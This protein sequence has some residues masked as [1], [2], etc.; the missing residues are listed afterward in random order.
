MGTTTFKTGQSGNPKGRPRLR[1]LSVSEYIGRRIG[2]QKTRAALVGE[3]VRIATKGDSD[4]A[5]LKAI[6]ALFEQAE[7]RPAQRTAAKAEDGKIEVI[8]GDDKTPATS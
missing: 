1:D 2:A 5:R 6:L 7:G 4:G 3:L 8:F